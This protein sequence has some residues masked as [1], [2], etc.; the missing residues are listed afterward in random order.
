MMIDL[1]QAKRDQLP[2]NRMLD[3]PLAPNLRITP[4]GSRC[5]ADANILKITCNREH[6]IPG[7]REILQSSDLKTLPR[8]E[9]RCHKCGLMQTLSSQP[10][11]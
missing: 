6:A 8:W 3:I 10:K 5:I 9:V 2:N 7:A 1:D 11:A 4:Y